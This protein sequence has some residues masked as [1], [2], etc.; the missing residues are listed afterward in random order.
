LGASY[1][2]P[3]L[4]VV[5]VFVHWHGVFVSR[6][7]HFVVALTTSQAGGVGGLSKARKYFGDFLRE[8]LS[9]LAALSRSGKCHKSRI[10]RV[11][12]NCR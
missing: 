11:N 2:V 3:W 6:S 1:Q 9:E 12:R 5:S 4:S 10:F 7:E 8:S